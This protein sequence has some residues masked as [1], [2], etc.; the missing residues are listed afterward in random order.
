MYFPIAESARLVNEFVD[1]MLAYFSAKSNNR[2][3]MEA[4][5]PRKSTNSLCSTIVELVT[6]FTAVVLG[7]VRCRPLCV[8]PKFGSQNGQVREDNEKGNED[9]TQQ[10]DEE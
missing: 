5:N 4:S 8:K 3:S 6:G 7:T 2:A 1:V 9:Q 10:N